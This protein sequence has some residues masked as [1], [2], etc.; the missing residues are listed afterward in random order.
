M[1]EVDRVAK[2]SCTG[3]RR[4]TLR[5]VVLCISLCVAE[6]TLHLLCAVSPRVRLT[7]MSSWE[8]PQES[9]IPDES[10]R[11]RGNLS[12]PDHDRQGY[13]NEQVPS[14]ADVIALGDS[15]TYGQGVDR[16]QAWPH[17]LELRT[18]K[19][20][21]NMGISGWG[22]LHYRAVLGEGLRLRPKVA[23]VA[24]YFGND[25]YDAYS[26]AYHSAL[27]NDLRTAADEAEIKQLEQTAP[28][29][30][31]PFPVSAVSSTSSGTLRQFCSAHCK[32][33]AVLRT[34]A[35]A[36]ASNQ[37][38]DPFLKHL[39]NEQQWEQLDLWARGLPEHMGTFEFRHVRTI[40]RAP[41]RFRA[42]NLN[43]PRIV[44]G[45][46]VTL[47]VLADMA[48]LCERENCCFLVL[49]IPSKEYVLAPFVTSPESYRS[50]AELVEQETKAKDRVMEELTS[51]RIPY[52][53]SLPALREFVAHGQESPYFPS[54]DGHPTAAGHATLG[55]VLSSHTLFSGKS[56]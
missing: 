49:L 20:V 36:T 53:D 26:S 47:D 38:F 56:F 42:V 18:G 1:P 33:Y 48:A 43:D 24:L 16:E 3:A 30:T 4:W 14:Q 2:A 55:E 44:A 17:Q 25:F 54:L 34:L 45:L 21:Y 15:Q 12:F 7:L 46:N 50:F 28:F 39:D 40:L 51:R 9:F 29:D 23:V 11:H 37:E 22:P 31:N 19:S 32:L 27:G 52:V 13:R 5:F 6:A 10:L 8:R 41:Q 35:R